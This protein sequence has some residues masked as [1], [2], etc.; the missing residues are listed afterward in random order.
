MPD[1]TPE[2]AT[3]A[4]IEQSIKRIRQEP[5]KNKRRI[6]INFWKYSK[7]QIKGS[8]RRE[9]RQ[10]WRKLWSLLATPNSENRGDRHLRRLEKRRPGLRKPNN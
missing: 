4:R 6:W 9:R 7:E 3:S 1:Q 10:N 5:R 2:E 8:S